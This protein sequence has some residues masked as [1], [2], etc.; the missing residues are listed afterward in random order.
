MSIIREPSV[1]PSFWNNAP[2][3]LKLAV[4]R[5][6]STIINTTSPTMLPRYRFRETN[7]ERKR[8]TK[9]TTTITISKTTLKTTTTPVRIKQRKNQPRPGYPSYERPTY[10]WADNETPDIFYRNGTNTGLVPLL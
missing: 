1:K 4:L 5:E 6:L 8:T 2:H 10:D 3:E 7:Y 9:R